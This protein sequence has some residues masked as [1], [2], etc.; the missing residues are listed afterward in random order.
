MQWLR[1]SGDE[2]RE[3]QDNKKEAVMRVRP[4]YAEKENNIEP[5]QFGGQANLLEAGE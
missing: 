4:T 1:T 2:V 3:G 5:F